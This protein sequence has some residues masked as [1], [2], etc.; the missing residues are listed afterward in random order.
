MAGSTMCLGTTCIDETHLG[1]L[2]RLV[3][4]TGI[5]KYQTDGG[6]GGEKI[7]LARPRTAGQTNDWDY[8]SYYNTPYIGY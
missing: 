6:G 1:M 5:F 7:S 8:P 3:N 4:G 2:L